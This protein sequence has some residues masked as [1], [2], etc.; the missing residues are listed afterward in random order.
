MNSPARYE[1]IFSGEIAYK[2]RL[3][4]VKQ[5]MATMFQLDR[6]KLAALFTGRPVVVKKNLTKDMAE[7]YKLAIIK[8]GGISRVEEMISFQSEETKTDFIGEQDD[9]HSFLITA[10]KCVCPACGHEAA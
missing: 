1:I 7:K 8:A 2:K 3:A 4:D 5:Q 6:G 10:K 9:H